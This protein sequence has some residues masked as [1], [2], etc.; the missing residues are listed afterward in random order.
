MNRGIFRERVAGWLV[1]VVFILAGWAKWGQA[2][3]LEGQIRL[4]GLAPRPVAFWL[5]HYLPVLEMVM[6][7]GLIAGY[8]RQAHWLGTGVLLGLFSV[9]LVGVWVLDLPGGCRCFGGEAAWPVP[10]ALAR[11]LV[12]MGVCWAGWRWAGRPVHGGLSHR[13]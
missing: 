4:W 1:G 6:G 3:L 7:L 5:G 8:W 11:N 10:W 9:V 12:L 2:D 13:C